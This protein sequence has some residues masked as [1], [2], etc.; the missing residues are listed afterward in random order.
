MKKLISVLM[1][2]VLVFAMGLA[3]TGCGGNE[4][5]KY[6][7]EDF[8]KDMAK[9]LEARWDLSENKN[10]GMAEAMPLLRATL[11]ACCEICTTHTSEMVFTKNAVIIIL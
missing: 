9:G 1:T 4:E 8:L 11:M 5:T 2:A 7:D 6:C 3:V 10:S